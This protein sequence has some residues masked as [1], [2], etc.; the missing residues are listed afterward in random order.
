[1]FATWVSYKIT[2]S[3]LNGFQFPRRVRQHRDPAPIEQTVF[4]F[5]KIRLNQPNFRES[6]RKGKEHIQLRGTQLQGES[7]H[8]RCQAQCREPETAPVCQDKTVPNQDGLDKERDRETVVLGA[9]KNFGRVLLCWRE[10]R[11][12]QELELPGFASGCSTGSEACAS[13]SAA[14][15]RRSSGVP[16]RATPGS[17]RVQLEIRDSN[18]VQTSMVVHTST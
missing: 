1:M 8:A 18:R 14:T 5:S 12:Q 2:R 4:F 6:Q 3:R 11:A 10:Q 17:L 9:S 16:W 13:W 15:R 7:Q